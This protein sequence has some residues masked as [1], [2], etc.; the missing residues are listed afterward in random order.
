MPAAKVLHTPTGE[1]FYTDY[2]YLHMSS[3]ILVFHQLH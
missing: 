3:G 2:D 1:I